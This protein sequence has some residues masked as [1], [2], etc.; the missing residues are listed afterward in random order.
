MLYSERN[1]GTKATYA[2][3]KDPNNHGQLT[4]VSISTNASSS[5]SILHRVSGVFLPSGY[6]GSVSSDYLSYQIWDTVQAFASSISGSLATQV[7]LSV[8]LDLSLI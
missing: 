6:P 5:L 4:K 3:I 1:D 8:C 2:Y 7:G